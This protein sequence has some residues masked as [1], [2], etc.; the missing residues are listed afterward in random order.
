MSQEKLQAEA[1]LQMVEKLALT[2]VSRAQMA[3]QCGYY[4]STTAEDGKPSIQ[5]ELEAFYYAV[6]EAKGIPKDNWQKGLM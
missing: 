3:I 1:L 4:T 2:Y 5:A 6:L